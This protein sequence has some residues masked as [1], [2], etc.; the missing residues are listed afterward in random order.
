MSDATTRFALP[1]IAP[2]Q[3]QK[4]LFHNEALARVDALLQPSVRHRATGW[5]RRARSRSGRKAA[6][7]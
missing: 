3:A 4:E 5:G 6:G 1:L 7:G 2:G